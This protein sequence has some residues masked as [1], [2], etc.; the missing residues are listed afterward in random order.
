MLADCAPSG[1]R[2]PTITRVHT[3]ESPSG[4][5]TKADP[6]LAKD[7]SLVMYLPS[8]S[9]TRC[10]IDVFS[11]TSANTT[12]RPRPHP[13]VDQRIARRL[14]ENAYAIARITKAPNWG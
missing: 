6:T 3:D 10:P 9:N 5:N 14:V 7:S 12:C 1:P 2:A 11:T 13:T 8:V 4:P